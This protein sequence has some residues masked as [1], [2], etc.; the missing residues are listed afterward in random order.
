ME[1]HDG[2]G[3]PPRSSS[4]MP[5]IVTTFAGDYWPLTTVIAEATTPIRSA[6]WPGLPCRP[7][8]SDGQDFMAALQVRLYVFFCKASNSRSVASI[9][10]PAAGTP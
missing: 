4:F 8:W 2:H 1:D 6:N 5:S 10:C 9:P 3:R 7:I